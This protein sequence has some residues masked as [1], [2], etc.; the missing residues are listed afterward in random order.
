MAKKRLNIELSIE[1]YEALRKQASTSGTTVSGV[2][3]Q[4]IAKS[5]DHLP[6]DAVKSYRSDPLYKRRGSFDGPRYL[7]EKHDQYLWDHA[8]SFTDCT[9]F[10]LMEHLNI[11]NAF[12]FD[13]HFREYGRSRMAQPILGGLQ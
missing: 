5:R 9:S 3:R 7:A 6:I 2:I 4:L 13:A 10:A 11:S 8:F 1:Q 12:A